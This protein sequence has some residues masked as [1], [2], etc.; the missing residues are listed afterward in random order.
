[1]RWLIPF[2]LLGLQIYAQPQREFLYT[3]L[4]NLSTHQLEGIDSLIQNIRSQQLKQLFV[5]EY[6]FLKDGRISDTISLDDSQ[7]LTGGLEQ[8]LAYYLVAKQKKRVKENATSIHR[9]LSRG[10]DIAE[11]HNEIRLKKAILSEII[12]SLTR[13]SQKD[14]YMIDLR[15]KYIAE[16]QKLA[17]FPRDFYWVNSFLLGKEMQKT[18]IDSLKPSKAMRSYLNKMN[19]NLTDSPDL[20]GDYHTAMGVYLEVFEQDYEGSFYHFQQAKVFFNSVPYHYAQKRLASLNHSLGVVLFRQQKLSQA[21][22]F[23]K[24]ALEANERNNDEMLKMKANDLLYQC[25]LAKGDYENAL[26]YFTAYKQTFDALDQKKYAQFILKMNNSNEL[27]KKEDE[28]VH[29]HKHNESLTMQFY[30]VMGVLGGLFVLALVL[31][32]LYKKNKKNV[33]KL[34]RS[35][36]KPYLLCNDKSMVYFINLMYIKADDKYIHLFISGGKTHMVRGTLNGVESELTPNFIRTHR[37]YIVNRNFVRQV[38]HQRLF[39]IDG[40]AI[41]LSRTFGK[42]IGENLK[43]KKSDPKH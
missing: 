40:T 30:S 22:P 24:T 2:V 3:I 13:F 38:Q 7:P 26:R 37:S 23:F 36:I 14:L 19:A 6:H 34:T 43:N 16:Y 9:D 32:K 10:L 12:Y 42:N 15:E 11:K 20:K 5:N 39:L 27:K 31:Y 33:E 21:I 4:N 17:T 29:L 25:Y 1:M 28:L 35:T 18:E 8:A 41:P